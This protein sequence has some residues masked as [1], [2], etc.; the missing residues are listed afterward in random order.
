[1]LPKTFAFS[2]LP[3]AEETLAQAADEVEIQSAPTYTDTP[4]GTASRVTV[5]DDGSYIP[6]PPELWS[7]IQAGSYAIILLLTVVWL[8][9]GGLI[10]EGLKALKELNNRHAEANRAQQQTVE[11]LAKSMN[12]L[13]DRMQRLADKVADLRDKGS[14]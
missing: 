2:L 11:T 7:A 8:R 12:E 3:T 1:M 14:D 10:S 5:V 13:A 9:Y 6:S 4:E